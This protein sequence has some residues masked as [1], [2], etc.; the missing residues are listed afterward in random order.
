MKREIIGQTQLNTI[1]RAMVRSGT[2]FICGSSSLYVPSLKTKFI[3]SDRV[4]EWD[5]Q[6][7]TAGEIAK[8]ELRREWPTLK[9]VGW[10]GK[11]Y[12]KLV[13]FHWPMFCPGPASGRFVYTDLVAAYWQIYSRLWLDTP[14]PCGMGSLDL[15]P[16]ALR[17]RDHKQARNALVGLCR[18][19]MI[20]AV[21]KGR[22]IALRAKNPFLSPGLWATVMGVLQEVAHWAIQFGASYCMMD[23]FFHP[24]DSDWKG[25][26][27]FLDGYGLEYRTNEYTGDIQGWGAWSM[28]GWKQTKL[29]GKS[30]GRAKAVKPLFP[31]SLKM[32]N[33]WAIDVLDYRIRRYG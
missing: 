11:S 4:F 5:G 13:G 23:G 3:R 27:T 7:L 2:F 18:S 28:F 10:S 19:S 6:M 8:H 25:F 31:N 30:V 21:S 16:V 15:A 33:Y 1:K 9:R 12:M 20:T 17:L 32:L 24:Y 29:Y 22:N 26:H 14:F